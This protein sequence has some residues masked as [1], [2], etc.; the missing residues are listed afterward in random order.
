MELIALNE[1]L[2]GHG[3]EAIEHDEKYYSYVNMGDMDC[4][5]IIDN[6]GQLIIVAYSDFREQLEEQTISNC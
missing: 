2:E 4:P 3:V 1:L 5:T 6:Y